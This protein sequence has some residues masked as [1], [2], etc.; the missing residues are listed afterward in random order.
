M[1]YGHKSSSSLNLMGTVIRYDLRGLIGYNV[2]CLSV[3][4]NHALPSQSKKINQPEL[5]LHSQ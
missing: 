1:I 2:L 4:P 5:N 3:F